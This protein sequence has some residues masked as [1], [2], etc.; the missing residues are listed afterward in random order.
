MD[1]LCLIKVSQ[2]TEVPSKS[3]VITIWKTTQSIVPYLSR[4]EL[5]HK[6]STQLTGHWR[7]QQILSDHNALPIRSLL[8]RDISNE[9]NDPILHSTEVSTVHFQNDG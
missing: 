5:F 2:L 9:A 6:S 7:V 8:P 1:I 4:K 3:T